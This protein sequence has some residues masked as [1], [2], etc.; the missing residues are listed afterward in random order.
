MHVIIGDLVPIFIPQNHQ[1]VDTFGIVVDI[2]DHK[3]Y[4]VLCNQHVE[5]WSLSDLTKMAK[6]K[7]SWDKG[8]ICQ[9]HF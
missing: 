9:K 4:A 5:Y 1:T 3:K 8:E 2:I 6:W 7:K